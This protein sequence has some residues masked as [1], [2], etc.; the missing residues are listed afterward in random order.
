M[1]VCVFVCA[2]LGVRAR[3]R[4]PTT[5]AADAQAAIQNRPAPLCSS[6]PP[7]PPNRPRPLHRQGWVFLLPT[8]TPEDAAE[9]F[10]DHKVRRSQGLEPGR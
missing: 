5:N 8:V 9:Y 4:N 10:P 2:R 1:C 3:V 7:A 6:Q